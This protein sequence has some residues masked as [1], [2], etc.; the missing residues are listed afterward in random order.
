MQI[1]EL[2]QHWPSRGHKQAPSGVVHGHRSKQSVMPSPSQSSGTSQSSGIMSPSQSASQPSGTEL[3]LQS[4]HVGSSTGHWERSHSSAMP[5][6]LQ[7]S[8]HSSG[9]PLRSQSRLVPH[10]SVQPAPPQST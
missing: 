5:L 2:K 9:T 10:G 4:L 3:P 8:W 7:S 6:R 1:P